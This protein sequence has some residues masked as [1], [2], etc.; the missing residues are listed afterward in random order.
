M[1]EAAATTIPIDFGVADDPVK[2]GLVA[3]LAEVTKKRLHHNVLAIA[4]A[5]KLARLDRAG[6]DHG[7]SSNTLA[8]LAGRGA[9]RSRWRD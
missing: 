1:S 9:A 6:A 2:L 4:L 3:S 8:A 7:S 5:N